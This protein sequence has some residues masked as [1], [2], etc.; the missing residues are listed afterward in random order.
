MHLGGGAGPALPLVPSA[1]VPAANARTGDQKSSSSL[2]NPRTGAA[3][4][5]SRL[6]SPSGLRSTFSMPLA[7]CS[8]GSA[9]HGGAAWGSEI[10][11]RAALDDREENG[12]D[13]HV[14]LQSAAA[15]SEA[16]PWYLQLGA[17]SRREQTPKDAEMQAIKGRETEDVRY[18]DVAEYPQDVEIQ[19]VIQAMRYAACEELP[20]FNGG[21][22][23]ESLPWPPS[24]GDNMVKQFLKYAHR[25]SLWVTELANA[26][27]EELPPVLVENISTKFTTVLSDISQ[28]C[29]VKYGPNTMDTQA[30]R[31]SMVVGL[32]KKHSGGLSN[33]IVSLRAGSCA[34]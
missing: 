1:A 25:R 23:L 8:A 7:T 28:T 24:H 10:E 15:R 29:W 13:A 4:A 27:R 20:T 31:A 14:G 12:D 26:A 32:I 6:A 5:A 30:N 22:K 2:P 9:A 33:W 34:V 3:G 11:L 19:A 17:Q 18:R 21:I 16:L